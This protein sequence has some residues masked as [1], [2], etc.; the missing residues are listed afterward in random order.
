MENK[1]YTPEIEE[2]FIGYELE[3]RIKPDPIE[4]ATWTKYIIC[5]RDNIWDY[6]LRTPYLCKQDI[7]SLGWEFNYLGKDDW[8]KIHLPKNYVFDEIDYPFELW[9]KLDKYWLGFYNA[10][11]KI[12]ILEKGDDFLN[13]QTIRFSGNCPSIN[14]LKYIQKLLGIK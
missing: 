7:E 9:F 13:G 14:E 6:E 2:L 12:V 11:Y 10:I 5:K 3:F 4:G 1:Y 8:F